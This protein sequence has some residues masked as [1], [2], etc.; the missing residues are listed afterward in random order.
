LVGGVTQLRRNKDV[1][2]R[3]TPNCDRWQ[4]DITYPCIS[5]NTNI[6]VKG[7]SKVYKMPSK[8]PPSPS[9]SSSSPT[10]P[11]FPI[12]P[13]AKH[14]STCASK[15]YDVTKAASPALHTDTTSSDTVS[16]PFRTAAPRAKNDSRSP[17]RRSPPRSASN[18]VPTRVAL[19]IRV[20]K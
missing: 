10:S 13:P 11:L 6:V 8:S 7:S 4:V 1:C 17:S 12:S 15:N 19:P 16:G 20:T 2:P 3:F 14:E 9:S 18:G 5:I